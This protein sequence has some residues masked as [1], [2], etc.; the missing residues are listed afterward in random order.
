MT[1]I[2]Q[3]TDTTPPVAL[4]ATLMTRGHVQTSRASRAQLRFETCARAVFRNSRSHWLSCQLPKL[5]IDVTILKHRAM[6]HLRLSPYTSTRG[7]K[8]ALLVAC[9][10]SLCASGLNSEN[11]AIWLVPGRGRNFSIL[12]AI[13]GGF[14]ARHGPCFLEEKKCYSPALVGPYWEKLCP[15][16]WVRLRGQF[17]LIRTSRPVNNIRMRRVRN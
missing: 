14:V 15:L 1:L 17:F 3:R 13:S 6:S 5:F 9:M 7:F 11:H 16:S 2:W 4:T 12:S 10:F 8:F